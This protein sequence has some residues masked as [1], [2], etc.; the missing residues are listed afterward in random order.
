MTEGLKILLIDDDEEDALI[1]RDLIRKGFSKKSPK[2]DEARSVEDAQQL[3][4]E[5]IYDVIIV[6]YMIG[7]SDGMEF[8]D[9]LIAEGIT[10]P[11][12]MLTGQGG[13][14]VAVD[15]MK[16]GVRDYLNK[17]KLSQELLCRSISNA[18]KLGELEHNKAA[19]EKAL[20]DSELKF[21][22]LVT[23]MPAIVC[24]LNSDGT[25]KLINVAVT[26]VLGYEVEELIGV[27]WAEWFITEDEVGGAAER[28]EQFL[29]ACNSSSGVFSFEL[30]AKAK[31]DAKKYINW[32]ITAIGE[33]NNRSKSDAPSHK[34][35]I[36]IGTDVTEVVMLRERLQTLSIL[37][38][39]TSLY[40]RRG[41]YTLAEQQIKIAKR[42]GRR[43]TVVF[44]DLDGL[45]QINDTLGHEAGDT[46]IVG[47]SAVL[48]EAFRESDI[49]A[50]IGG[51]EFI[52]LV[53]DS[54]SLDVD[55]IRT[56]IK[57]GVDNFNNTQNQPFKLSIS[58]GVV[59]YDPE[60]D[61]S[62]DELTKQADALMYEN[63]M[64]KKANTN[65]N[66][67]R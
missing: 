8:V 16:R 49:I 39:L 65:P 44:L 57:E 25:V 30:V 4:K 58:D 14:S 11:I 6:D 37:D 28:K 18:V 31:K 34:R 19:A 43:M 67:T 17:W 23:F 50:R 33:S 41:F 60:S 62:I 47:A 63:K 13:E 26:T 29:T 7:S 36:C 52:V 32:N 38:E 66:S 9:W 5:N 22:E 55:I 53:T 21:R 42:Y 3:V 64:R 45:K 40:N 54:E 24:E 20:M 2:I 61:I 27:S 10:V 59:P 46:A 1:A 35:V 48:R 56:R 51:D 15:A 12:I